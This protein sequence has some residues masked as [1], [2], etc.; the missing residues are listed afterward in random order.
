MNR[1]IPEDQAEAF[2]RP[3]GTY[4]PADLGP[5]STQTD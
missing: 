3:L 2:F 4:D 1:R 5:L